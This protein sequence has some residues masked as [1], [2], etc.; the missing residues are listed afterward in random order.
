[1]VA[2]PF[3]P[4]MTAQTAERT[5]HE[6]GT[7]SGKTIRAAL[8]VISIPGMHLILENYSERRCLYLFSTFTDSFPRKN[9]N[10]ASLPCI[11]GMSKIR[12]RSDTRLSWRDV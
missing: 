11:S 9:I 8:A 3:S 1:M 4:L 5:D 7:E 6:M 12:V 10:C 2:P